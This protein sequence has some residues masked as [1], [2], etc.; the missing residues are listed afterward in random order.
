MQI[1]NLTKEDIKRNKMI[2]LGVLLGI[3]LFISITLW[4]FF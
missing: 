2:A 4:W 1:T 3:I